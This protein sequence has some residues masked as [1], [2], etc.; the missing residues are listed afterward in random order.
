MNK[1]KFI[2]VYVERLIKKDPD[3]GKYFDNASTDRR[4]VVEDGLRQSLDHAYEVYAGKY[5][6]TKGLGSYLVKFLR[7]TGAAADAVGTYAFWALGGAGFTFKGLGLVEKSLADLVEA[8][9]FQK[10]AKEDSLADRVKDT[11]KIVG[12]GLVERA[13]AYLP[14]GIGE[15]TDLVRGTGKYDAKV[16]TKA[17]A[18]AKLD[19]IKRYGAYEPRE[20]KII[21]LDAFRIRRYATLDE[22]VKKAA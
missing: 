14:L 10:H 6:S 20:A 1:T 22:H 18:N 5:F 15:L 11:G 21:S 4:K 9:H 17:V 3:I 7:W 8:Y 19:F 2:D 12:E 16:L 13:A